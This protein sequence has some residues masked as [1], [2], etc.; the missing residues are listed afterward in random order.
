MKRWLFFLYGVGCHLMFLA[1]YAALAAFVGGFVLP[2]TIDS[3]GEG[4]LAAA[5]AIDLLLL[6]AFAAQHSIMARP[7][8][9]RIWTR[10]V[11]QPIERSTYVLASNLVTMLLMWQ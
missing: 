8:F 11:P 3:A 9:K 6:A 1:V 2:W 5:I 7:A 10:V 4:T